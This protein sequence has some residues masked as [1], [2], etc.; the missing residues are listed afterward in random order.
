[1]LVKSKED[2]NRN[3]KVE[4]NSRVG[5]RSSHGFLRVLPDTGMSQ[6]TAG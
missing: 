2:K 4:K 5:M 6:A 1:M 3:L